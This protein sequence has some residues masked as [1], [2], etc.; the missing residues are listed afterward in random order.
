MGQEQDR[1]R[2][3]MQQLERNSELYTRYVQKFAQQESR[4]ETLRRETAEF[5]AKEAASRKALDDYVSQIELK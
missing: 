4:V 5:E 1:I 3:N 2:Q